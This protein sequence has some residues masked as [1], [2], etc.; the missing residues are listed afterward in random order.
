MNNQGFR[1]KKTIIATAAA[2][3]LLFSATP[4]LAGTSG[5]SA[6]PSTADGQIDKGRSRFTFQLQPGE[7]G[8]DQIYVSNT[9]TDPISL[10]IYANDARSLSDGTYDVQTPDVPP[11]DVGS[12]VSFG[13]GAN[14][15]EI[16][17]GHDESR[18][19]PFT[20][21]IPK[22]ATPG[23]H[24]GGIAV[25][26]AS[27][28]EGQIKVA[29]RIVTRLYARIPGI[30]APNLTVSNLTAN[31]VP[32]IN[33][34]DGTINMSFTI[35]NQGNVSL[36]ADTKASATTLFGIPVGD[37]SVAEV[38]EMTPGS[39]RSY[40]VTVPHVGQWLWI[41]PKVT[42]TPKVDNDAINPGALAIVDREQTVWVFPFS[43]AAILVLLGFVLLALRSRLTRRRKQVATWLA[44]AEAEAEKKAREQD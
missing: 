38:E 39:S 27:S 43:W 21:N 10:S 25:A 3:A 1:L 23:D 36:K 37:V 16:R 29:R 24:A 28:G 22:D 6:E 26:A 13:K 20:I 18:V 14:S 9:G 44:F 11:T 34:F 4:A 12:W 19:V 2:I 30:L 41:N 15:I 33:P 8:Q 5:F 32:S 35:N 31:Y 42:L 40:M 17:L 7:S